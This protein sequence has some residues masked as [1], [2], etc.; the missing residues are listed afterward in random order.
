[1]SVFAIMPWVACVLCETLEQLAYRMAGRVSH[2]RLAWIT[3]GIGWH[4]LLLVVWFWL[5]RLVPLGVAMPL[6]GASYVTTAFASWRL[7]QE[8]VDARRW[9]GIVVITVGLALICGKSG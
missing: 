4:I 9:L 5:L 7:F 6:M 8:N 1:M 2:R 3:L